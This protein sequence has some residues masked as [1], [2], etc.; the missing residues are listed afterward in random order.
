M[1]DRV[2]NCACVIHGDKYDWQYVDHLYRM[3]TRYISGEV[4][5]HV[6]TEPSRRVPDIYTKHDLTEWAGVSGPRKSWWYKMQMFNPKFAVTGPMLF[7]DLDIVIVDDINW[8]LDLPLDKFWA[9]KDFRYLWRQDRQEINSSI[10]YWE[11]TKFH[12]IWDG[13]TRQDRSATIKRF[14][15][16][17]DYLNSVLPR[18]QIGFLDPHRILSYRWQIKDGGWSN[19]TRSHRSPGSGA[20]I[21]AGSSVIVFHGNPKPHEVQEKAISQHWQ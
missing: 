10:M 21:P 6:W 9:V 5:L 14:A 12:W 15:G 17:Q 18:E 19:H 4:R 11:P 8:I 2:V 3:L 16:D 7:F 13:W 20:N 1:S